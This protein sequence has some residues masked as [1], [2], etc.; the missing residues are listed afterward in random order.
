MC[1]N[2]DKVRQNKGGKKTLIL[3][4]SIRFDCLSFPL[5]A[6]RDQSIHRP[7]FHVDYQLFCRHSSLTYRATKRSSDS[8]SAHCEGRWAWDFSLRVSLAPLFIASS[9]SVSA[10]FCFCPSLFF[11]VMEGR[12]EWRAGLLTAGL[13]AF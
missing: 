6:S 10:Y 1:G 11:S 4:C 5:K 7:F 3:P 9:L 8:H 13:Q 2:K 12:R